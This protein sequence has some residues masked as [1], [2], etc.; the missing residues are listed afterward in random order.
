MAQDAWQKSTF[1]GGGDHDDCVQIAA[2][3][4]TVL[5]RESEEPGQVVRTTPAGLAA[6]IRAIRAPRY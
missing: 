4:H 1:S 5:L 6:L 3:P 2:H